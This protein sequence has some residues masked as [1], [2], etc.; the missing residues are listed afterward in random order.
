MKSQITQE[1]TRTIEHRR[2]QK[3]KKGDA[4]NINVP[5]FRGLDIKTYKYILNNRYFPVKILL[6]NQLEHMIDLHNKKYSKPV[7]TEVSDTSVTTA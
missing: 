3:A 1:Q 7:A 5:I 6:Q 2:N 4:R